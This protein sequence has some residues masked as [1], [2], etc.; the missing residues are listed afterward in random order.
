MGAHPTLTI[1]KASKSRLVQPPDLASDGRVPP[2]AF[3][4]AWQRLSIKPPYRVAFDDANGLAG[5]REPKPFIGA[6]IRAV[7]G[8]GVSS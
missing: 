4:R 2:A 5:L 1:G 6:R 7:H 8:K 3:G